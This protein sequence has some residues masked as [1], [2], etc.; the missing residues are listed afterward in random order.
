[1]SSKLKICVCT[2]NIGNA[3]P[4]LKSVAAWIPPLGQ[5]DALKP[6]EG[7]TDMTENFD[8]I[9]VG[10]QEST[11]SKGERQSSIEDDDDDN[12]TNNGNNN[13]S[14]YASSEIKDSSNKPALAKVLSKP[15]ALV[16][17]MLEEAYDSQ[18]LTKLLQE[19]LGSDYQLLASQ[20]RG[21]MRLYIWI[22]ARWEGILAREHVNIKC[23]NTGVGHVLANKGGIVATLTLKKHTHFLL[24]G[25]LGGS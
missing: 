14:E 1:M 22:H 20:Q 25:A 8:L 23:E 6:L 4:D 24:D 16:E 12:D 19:T 13:D 2:A 9:V 5:C 18:T 10:M 11:F 15:Q 21:Q 7:G 17:E 3:E